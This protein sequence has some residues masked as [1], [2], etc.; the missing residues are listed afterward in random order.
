M[1]GDVRRE[2]GVPSH[3]AE[4]LGEA[5]VGG[6]WTAPGTKKKVWRGLVWDLGAFPCM[7]Q[8]VGQGRGWSWEFCV[9]FYVEW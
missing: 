4:E 2:L 3:M 8:A 7:G 5:L 1:P 9:A 6:L